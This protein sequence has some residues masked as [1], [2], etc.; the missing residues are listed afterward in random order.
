VSVMRDDRARDW[1]QCISRTCSFSTLR[2]LDL[3]DSGYLTAAT[4]REQPL[5][6]DKKGWEPLSPY[7]YDFTPCFVDVWVSSV[8]LFGIVFGAGA[9][10]WL[11]KKKQTAEVPKNWHF[12]TK[13]VCIYIRR[14]QAACLGIPCID[15]DLLTSLTGLDYYNCGGGSLPADPPNRQLPQRMGRR[16]QI[17]DD[18]AYD[19]LAGRCLLDT[20]ARTQQTS[21]SQRHRSP[22]LALPADSIHGQ[23][24]I[25]HLTTN[26]RY[27]PLILR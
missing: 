18:G 17:L 10:W 11:I 6:G 3:L 14:R 4:T 25:S 27:P 22:L 13:Q 8:A 24:A 26:I 15:R 9:L 20:V 2:T 16:L 7:R 12:W 21:K 1:S 5:C 23:I 19:H